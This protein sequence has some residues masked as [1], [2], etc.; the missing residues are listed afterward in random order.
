MTPISLRTPPAGVEDSGAMGA[1]ENPEEDESGEKQE[2]AELGAPL[3]EEGLG[4]VGFGC[5]FAGHG[6]RV[7]EEDWKG[8]ILR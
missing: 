6:A 3:A 1:V 7:P 4:M 5:G 8:V 2:T